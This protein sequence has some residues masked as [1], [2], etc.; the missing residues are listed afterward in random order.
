MRIVSLT[1]TEGGSHVHQVTG[2]FDADD[3]RIQKDL[4]GGPPA[5]AFGFLTEALARRRAHGVP[6]FTVMSCDN[7]PGNGEVAHRMIS[8][9]A[10]LKDAELSAWI[11][12]H[13]SF[14][15][16]MVDRI[17]LVTADADRAALAEGF[18]VEDGWPVVCEPFTQ[19]VLQ[20]CF[21]H[22]RPPLEDVGVQIVDDVEPYE[23]MKLRLLNAGHQAVCY[24]GYLS[25]YRY[26]HEV[27]SDPLFVK[28]LLGYMNEEGMPTLPPCLMWTWSAT[29]TS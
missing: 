17:T 10:K 11:E 9:F 19:W 5:T 21:P 12:E 1:I 23:L 20:D 26:A 7:I 29:S 2:E 22:G 28:S 24:L 6:P 16:S 4:L 15:N 25:G 13:V 14:P 18:G 8:A 27:S 3:P